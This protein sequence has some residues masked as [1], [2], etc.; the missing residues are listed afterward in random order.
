MP[1]ETSFDRAS[2]AAKTRKGDYVNNYAV[3][4]EHMGEQ[5]RRE[6]EI[7][8]SMSAALENEQFEVFFQPQI[9]L[10]TGAC[11][12]R[13]KRIIPKQNVRP[14]SARGRERCSVPGE[15]RPAIRLS[16]RPR[17]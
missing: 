15:C 16:G 9:D 6:Q 14:G 5:L 1:P 3:Y 7:V 12:G 2:L 10:R 17:R 11:A 4:A 13:R 8:N